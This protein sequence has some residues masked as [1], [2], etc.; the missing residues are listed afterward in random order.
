[1]PTYESLPT[2]SKYF[3]GILFQKMAE[4]LR[5]EGKAKRTVYGYLRAIRQLA[6]FCQKRPDK[7]NEQDLRRY[8]LHLIVELEV[9]T[10]TQTVAPSGITATGDNQLRPASATPVQG[11][12]TVDME[13]KTIVARQ[14]QG[15][16]DGH[17]VVFD[18]ASARDD[19]VAFLVSLADGTVPVV[20]KAP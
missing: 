19:A 5:L 8:L 9:A 12:V 13:T 14:Y 4:D 15:P 6:D 20:P 3:N 7:L 10:G 18:V 17:F 1:M 11:N 2:E 16:G